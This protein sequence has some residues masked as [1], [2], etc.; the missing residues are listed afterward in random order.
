MDPGIN[1]HGRGDPMDFHGDC[2]G[3]GLSSRTDVDDNGAHKG[4]GP[5]D[6]RQSVRVF[7]TNES[8][9]SNIRSVSESRRERCHGED[10]D[11]GNKSKKNGPWSGHRHPK[12]ETNE[13][14]SK[15]VVVVV[16]GSK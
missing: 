8:Q 3:F 12:V 5:G 10:D 4:T 14:E 9:K 1:I 6:T 2:T 16:C 15:G 7:E 13:V 11:G